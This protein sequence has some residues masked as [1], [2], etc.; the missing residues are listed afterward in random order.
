MGDVART[1]VEAAE[2]GTALLWVRG[3]TRA[4]LEP[5]DL[6]LASG[7]LLLISGPSGAG[8]SLL[9]RALA[10]LDPNSGEVFLKG[11]PRNRFPAPQWRRLVTYLSATPGWWA[12]T[13]QE[14]FRPED[15]DI[16]AGMLARLGLPPQAME[17]D[18]D[19]LSTGE[20]QRLALLRALVQRPAV[21]LLD[22]PTGA[23]DAKSTAQ[24]EDFLRERLANGLAVIL[25]SHDR[26][27]GRRLANRIL[28]MAKGGKL[29]EG[30]P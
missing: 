2:A 5:A 15:K 25:V 7:E 24:V 10:D 14:H 11:E 18:V 12:P 6:E 30:P 8:K 23:L 13:V 26:A 9:L 4:G 28:V 27:Q 3:L 20:G 21:L 19:R 22:E 29:S 1:R 17:W 16:A